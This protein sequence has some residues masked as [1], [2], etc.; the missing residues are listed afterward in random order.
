MDNNACIIYEHCHSVCISQL[1]VVMRFIMSYKRQELLTLRHD[2]GSPPFLVEF[3]FIFLCL[4][5]PMLPVSL[6]C[7]FFITTSVFSD[8][9]LKKETKF[10]NPF[11][12]IKI[13]FLDDART[14]CLLC[15]YFEVVITKIYRQY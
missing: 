1:C 4:L 2:L 12:K 3:V 7:P 9:Y 15:K 8:D 11:L 10:S 13:L 5:Y 6:D 14:L